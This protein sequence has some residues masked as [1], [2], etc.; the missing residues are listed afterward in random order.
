MLP[1]FLRHSEK[2]NQMEPRLSLGTHISVF[3]AIAFGVY[4]LYPSAVLNRLGDERASRTKR[5][6]IGS[7][8]GQSQ[9]QRNQICP[10]QEKTRQ[11]QPRSQE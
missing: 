11:K 7:F 8:I 9:P 1:E 3:V 5:T 4:C 6:N 10:P 2:R